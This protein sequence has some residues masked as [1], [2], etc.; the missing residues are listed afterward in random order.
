MWPAG[1]STILGLSGSFWSLECLRPL[2][3]FAVPG[4]ALC[5]NAWRGWH[6]EAEGCG[7]WL[8]QP[9]SWAE[10]GPG[11]AW[12]SAG[13]CHPVCG[14][15]ALAPLPFAAVSSQGRPGSSEYASRAGHGRGTL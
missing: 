5:D 10:A 13:V 11:I 4:H 12:P 9:G 1:A 7:T 15:L 3:A 14:C 6:I 2:L 8:G